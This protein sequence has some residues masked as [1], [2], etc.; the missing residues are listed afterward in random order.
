MKEKPTTTD[1][2][3]SDLIDKQ[4]VAPATDDVVSLL[5]FHWP[6]GPPKFNRFAKWQE[7][8]DRF[9]LRMWLAA[10]HVGY[11][12]AWFDLGGLL[13]LCMVLPQRVIAIEDGDAPDD[14]FM[15]WDN[16]DSFTYQQH[17][18]P[19]LRAAWRIESHQ[20]LMLPNW[21]SR[22]ARELW[23]LRRK[24]RRARARAIN[25][26]RNPVRQAGDR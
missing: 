6:N 1:S 4:L 22:F 11:S 7:P 5:D 17:L 10:P 2:A 15:P 8:E 12:V 3:L 25:I 21:R 26:L 13:C 14:P 9:K 16:P 18:L 24:L 20:L 19:E 23:A